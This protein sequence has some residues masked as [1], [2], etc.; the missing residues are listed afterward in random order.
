MSLYRTFTATIIAAAV[1]ASTLL[2][3]PTE[4]VVK[5]ESKKVCMVNEASMAS[6]QIPVKVDGKTYYGCCAMCKEKLEKNAAIRSAVDPVSGKKVDKALAVIGA[7]PGGKVLY[8]ENDA[9]LQ[10]YN[11]SVVA[12][13]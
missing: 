4:R 9:N 8:F 1:S 13:K 6:D 12:E 3:G 7:L 11:A 10:R 5:V 2:A